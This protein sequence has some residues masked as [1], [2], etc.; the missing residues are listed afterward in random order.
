[1]RIS[2]VTREQFSVWKRMRQAVYSD[3]EPQFHDEEMNCLFSSGQAGCFLAWS[4]EGD[5]IG[6][7][8]ITLR[9]FVDGCIGSPVGYIEGIYLDPD[10]RGA[11]HGSRLVDFACE[12][13]ESRGCKDMATDAEITNSEA[14]AFYRR[15]GFRE[16]WHV[17]GF[18]KS[19]SGR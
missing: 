14:Q 7:L 11:G 8:E 16:R 5:A 12:W 13:F 3:L 2:A 10:H 17:V 19:L 4:D 9:N 15:H 6:L 18:T 1:M